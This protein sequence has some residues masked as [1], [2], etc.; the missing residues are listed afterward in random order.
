M[1]AA[2]TE[3]PD[4]L[5]VER[6][7]LRGAKIDSFGDHRIAMAF[8]VAGL[9]A[10]GETEIDGAECANI[11]FPGFFETLNGTRTSLSASS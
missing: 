7:E 10:D 11:S 9:F 4:G 3:F 6:S 5:K 1:G 2:V 8:G